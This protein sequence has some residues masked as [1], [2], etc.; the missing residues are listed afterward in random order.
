MVVQAA[1]GCANWHALLL[2]SGMWVDEV[3]WHSA[4]A[5]GEGWPATFVCWPRDGQRGVAFRW[6]KVAVFQCLIDDVHCSATAWFFETGSHPA[7]GVNFQVCVSAG[8]K[9]ASRVAKE[10][11]E[12]LVTSRRTVSAWSLCEV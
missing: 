10:A 9:V 5:L 7:D 12:F 8:A 2:V 1:G 6:H 4:C 3:G 11:L